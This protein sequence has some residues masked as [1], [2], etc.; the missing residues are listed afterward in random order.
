MNGLV[1]RARGW[2]G[3]RLR[4]PDPR[5]DELVMI[6]QRQRSRLDEQ[7][8]RLRRQ[9]DRLDRLSKA[10][11]ALSARLDELSDELETQR[12]LSRRVAELTHLVSQVLIPAANRS[13][14]DLQQRLREYVDAID[15]T[16]D[17]RL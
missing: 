4:R 11:Q 12:R 6:T 3:R 10:N 2:L 9:A 7:A 16:P 1:R 17:Q 13:D 8:E 5:T 15:P 14:A